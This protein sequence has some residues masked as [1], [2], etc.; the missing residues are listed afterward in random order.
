[1]LE[2]AGY[3]VELAGPGDD[4]EIRALLREPMGGGI[5]ISLEREPDARLAGAMEGDRHA[6]MVAR[7][8]T[9]RIAAMGSR[10]V[11]T[12]WLDGAPARLGYIGQL[13][14]RPE[15]S[16]AAGPLL[17]AGF[18]V[19]GSTRRPGEL[20]FDLTSIAAGNVPARR[21]LERGVRGVP[22]YLPLA[23]VVTC[24]VPTGGRLRR[25]SG[26]APVAAAA[27]AGAASA[28][29]PS[30]RPARSLA[31]VA[32]CLMRTLSREQLAPRW[33]EADLAPSARSRGLSLE[34]FLVAEGA[35]GEVCGCAA[36]WDQRA[37]KQSRVQR[38]P[39]ALGVLRP[40]LNTF[41]TLA[42]E[43]RLPPPGAAIR[44]GFLSHLSA[45]DDDPEVF[46]ALVKA[47]RQAARAR[48]L[49]WLVTGFVRGHPLL[50]ALLDATRART[51]E[52][53][54]YALPW[55]PEGPLPVMEGR[56]LHVE[57]ATL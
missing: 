8:R 5:R 13:R 10:S 31:E 40:L 36:V 19:L 41:R 28:G 30:V 57:V 7:D 6:T 43:P 55:S 15:A 37:F 17:R 48:G 3:R 9:G 56:R 26:G 20:P 49:D 52:T 54:L 21:L 53:I 24:L 47:G 51:Y 22:S 27:V 44:M 25:G 1:M 16:R 45:E 46:L 11:R 32:E 42:G 34:D 18:K 33:T 29:T 23:E 14:R 4:P 39:P 35:G 50:E 2:V 38:Y 12:V